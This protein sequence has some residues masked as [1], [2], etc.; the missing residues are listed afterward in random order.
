MLTSVGRALRKGGP[1]TRKHLPVVP[2]VMEQRGLTLHHPSGACWD[3]GGPVHLLRP[4]KE[5]EGRGRSPLEKVGNQVARD[6]LARVTPGQDLALIST[7]C[8][9]S[10][11]TLPSLPRG[12]WQIPVACTRP[13]NWGGHVCRAFQVQRVPGHSNRGRSRLRAHPRARVPRACR[14]EVGVPSSTLA[15]RALLLP[16]PTLTR[17]S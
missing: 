13:S 17:L 8:N 10:D 2:A 16:A 11:S 1:A 12:A 9:S 6:G 14:P 5:Q 3:G 4:G 7:L 15:P